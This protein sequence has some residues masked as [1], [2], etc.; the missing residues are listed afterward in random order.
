MAAMRVEERKAREAAFHDRAFSEET[1]QDL[2]S[3]YYRVVRASAQCYEDYLKS[4]CAGR[5]V[6]EYGCGVSSRSFLLA[7]CGAAAVTGIDISPVAIERAAQRA[8]GNGRE[9]VSFQLMDAERLDFP[10]DSFDLVCGTSIIHH[11][12]LERAYSEVSRVLRPEGSAIFVEPLGHNPLINLYRRRTPHLRTSDEHPLRMG[13]LRTAC[14][15]F[16]AV[17]ARFFH[18]QGLL[19]V[20]FRRTRAFDRILQALD[21]ADQALFRIAPFAGRYAWQV[22]IELGR[23][24][25]TRRPAVA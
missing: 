16:E 8:K 11:L 4:N 1:R 23:P 6:L 2:W 17:S 21:A 22:V 9:N 19:A 14:D 24:R 25:A 5:R 15:Y 20:P 12:D 3:K 18:L 10:D 13:D 7:D